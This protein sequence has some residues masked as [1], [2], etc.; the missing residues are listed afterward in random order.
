M[1][2]S[3]NSVELSH[4][5]DPKDHASSLLGQSQLQ[6]P[7]LQEAFPDNPWAEWEAPL[8]AFHTFICSMFLACFSALPND[9][10]SPKTVP[11]KLRQR[12]AHNK[13]SINVSGTNEWKEERNSTLRSEC[14]T[15]HLSFPGL[16]CRISLLFAVSPAPTPHSHEKLFFSPRDN[17]KL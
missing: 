10:R 9:F 4:L 2:W 14:H 15:T 1:P 17:L 13:C 11:K 16:T 6:D 5:K 8:G 12:L 7:F 3:W